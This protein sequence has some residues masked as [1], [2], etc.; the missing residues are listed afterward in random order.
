MDPSGIPPAISAFTAD[1][2]SP[3]AYGYSWPPKEREGALRQALLADPHSPAK[4]RVNAIVRN[5]D[6]WYAAFGV[7]PGDRLDLPPKQRVD[8]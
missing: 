8:T 4:Y 6:P 7:K 1:Q 3:I 5:F 2:R